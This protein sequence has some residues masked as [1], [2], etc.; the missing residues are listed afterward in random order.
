VSFLRQARIKLSDPGH[1]TP[2]QETRFHRIIPNEV[3]NL[4]PAW[5]PFD[6]GNGTWDESISITVVLYAY[7]EISPLASLG[8]DDGF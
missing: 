6:L 8:R 1:S 2:N 7:R 3:R 4:L 5:R